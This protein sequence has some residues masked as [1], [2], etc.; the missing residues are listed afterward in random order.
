M[1]HS[2]LVFFLIVILD[3]VAFSQE[4]CSFL[5]YNCEN[6]FDTSVCSNQNP[7]LSFTPNGKKEFNSWK[8]W[9]KI[10]NLSRVIR[11]SID[12]E[13]I[14]IGLAEVECRDVLEDLINVSGLQQEG[15]EI[16][17]FDSPDKRGIDVALLINTLKCTILSTN[18]IREDQFST[19]DVLQSTIEYSGIKIELIVAHF[20]SKRGGELQSEERRIQI[21]QN[22]I[23]REIPSRDVS[24]LMGDFNANPWSPCM[25]VLQ[26]TGF[27]W[28]KPQHARGTHTFQGHWDYLD[29]WYVSESK[30]QLKSKVLQFSFLFD[31]HQ[32][33]KRTYLGPHYL[34][35]Y[36]DHLP[37]LLHLSGF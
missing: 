14:A 12:K 37:I 28:V 10:S 21:S 27:K 11:N 25:K 20:P 29:C 36:S 4:H 3:L 35:G 5:F 17:H 1:Y 34:G 8:Y 6:A 7:D 18:I 32:N 33:P 2:I 15:F 23:Q 24:I 9:K 16:V 19:R 26:A 30:F 13:T 22:I 31:Q